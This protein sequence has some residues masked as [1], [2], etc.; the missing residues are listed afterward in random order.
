MNASLASTLSRLWPVIFR[1]AVILLLVLGVNHGVAMLVDFYLPTFDKIEMSSTMY[2]TLLALALCYAAL[3][4]VP[5]IPGVEIGIALLT[6]FGAAAAPVVYAATLL[7]LGLAYAT[8]RLMPDTLLTAGLYRIGA[9]GLANDI[10]ASADL[11]GRERVEALGR[12]S[13]PAFVRFLLRHDALSLALLLNLPGNA[14]IGGG[15]G[16]ALLSGLSRLYSAPRF[17]LIV[18]IAVA[19]VPLAVSFF[20][21]SPFGG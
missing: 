6:I 8:G 14:L 5:F 9:K 2:G 15:G 4:A 21:V 7:G 20:G 18:A 11:A 12:S 10:E 1:V 3:L 13:P 17:A 19:P 16:I